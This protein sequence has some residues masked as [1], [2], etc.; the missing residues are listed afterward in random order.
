M[1]P[2]VLYQKRT[3]VNELLEIS[4]EVQ[5]A[6][7]HQKP[8]VALEA[9]LINSGACAQDAF[10]LSLLVEKILREQAVTPAPIALYQGKIRIG[11]NDKIIQDFIAEQDIPRAS[12]RDLPYFLSQGINASTNISATMFCAHLAKLPIFVTGGIGGVHHHVHDSFDISSDLIELSSTPVTVICSGAKSILDLP[13]TLEMLETQGVSVIG[14][15]TDEFPAF[16]SR[17]SGIPLL[18]RVNTAQEV[19]KLMIYQ[20]ELQINNSL[21]IANPIHPSAEIPDEQILPVIKQ[22]QLE[23]SNVHG[24]SI[25]PFLLKRIAELT[26]GQSLQANI[27]L[28]KSNVQLGAQIAIAYQQQLR[29]TPFS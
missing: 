15:Q 1:H 3:I 13:K 9:P 26:A 10:E 8:V 23:L 7:A 16:F 22:A 25:T 18:H 27:E 4:E 5:Y 24:K 12:R 20:R 6:L 11:L 28:L 29:L 17:S 19:A 21:I 14:Y 2:L